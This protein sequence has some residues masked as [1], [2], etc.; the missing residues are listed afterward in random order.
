MAGCAWNSWMRDLVP[1]T[2][3]GRFFGR[4]AAANTA[5]ALT[6]ALLCG[7]SITVA[8]VLSRTIPCRLHWAVLTSAAIGFLGVWL[9][10]ITPDQPMPPASSHPV[11]WHACGTFP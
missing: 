9:L 6:L 8:A 7:V 5:I 4:R 10:S 2:A 11:H 1:E 3:Y